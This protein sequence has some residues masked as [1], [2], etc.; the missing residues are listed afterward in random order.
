MVR[1]SGWSHW[2]L[3]KSKA[4][5][6]SSRLWFPPWRSHSQVD[7]IHRVEKRP[8][9]AVGHNS[10]LLLQSSSEV[11]GPTLIGWDWVMCSSQNQSIIVAKER[12]YPDWWS[13]V[14]YPPQSRRFCRKA[15]CEQRSWAKK[16]TAKESLGLGWGSMKGAKGEGREE[17]AGP[18]AQTSQL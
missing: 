6:S 11:P 13:L 2:V 12:E 14:E 8:L 9:A 16:G 7:S 10:D 15:E 18:L 4:R 5:L 1:N 17:Q 3:Q